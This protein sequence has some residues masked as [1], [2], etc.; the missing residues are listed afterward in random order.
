MANNLNI[1][2]SLKRDGVLDLAGGSCKYVQGWWAGVLYR[3]W[4]HASY[5]TGNQRLNGQFSVSLHS[6][7]HYNIIR[8]NEY[9]RWGIQ[10]LCYLSTSL[11][12]M[13]TPVK[14]HF[15]S[16]TSLPNYWI[17]D[18]YPFEH[19]NTGEKS[20]KNAKGGL[21]NNCPKASK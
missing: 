12:L 19:L 6:Y 7:I 14:Q 9:K 16:P 13:S 5:R 15:P 17:L 1:K 4:C 3:A 11:V 20:K 2:I 21:W 18:F 8:I 10:F